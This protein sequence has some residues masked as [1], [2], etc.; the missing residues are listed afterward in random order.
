MTTDDP[1]RLGR[2]ALHYAALDG[3]VDQVRDLVASGANVAATDKQGFTPLHL[4]CQQYRADVVEVLLDA[5]APVDPI[6]AW[7]STPLYRAVFNAKGDPAVVRRLV[8]AGAD[9]DLA[10]ASG[11]SPREL[12]E[13]IASCDTSGFFDTPA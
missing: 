2:T 10:I 4:A 7:G 6:D 11:R 13:M 12:A 8:S 9:P 1:D 5:G 3:P